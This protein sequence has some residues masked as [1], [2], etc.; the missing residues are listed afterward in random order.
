MNWFNK[1]SAL[2]KEWMQLEKQEKLYL[3]KRKE[4]QDSKINLFLS[5]KVPANLQN[6]L[7]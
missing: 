4:K 6:T 7:E 5:E 2:E 3:D 1:K